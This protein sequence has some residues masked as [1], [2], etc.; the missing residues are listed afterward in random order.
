MIQPPKRLET[1]YMLAEWKH[2]HPFGRVDKG[3]NR[4]HFGYWCELTEGERTVRY[5]K[6]VTENHAVKMALEAW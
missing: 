5:A 6:G 4:G 3:R 1:K 2:D